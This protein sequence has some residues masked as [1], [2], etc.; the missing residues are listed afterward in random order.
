MRVAAALCLCAALGAGS[1]ATAEEAPFARLRGCEGSGP[2]DV[3]ESRGLRSCRPGRTPNILLLV[4][5][6]LGL[7][8][9]GVYG[10]RRFPTPNL[11]RLAAEGMRFTHFYSNS[12]ICSPARVAILTGQYP[13]RHGARFAYR[14]QSDHGLP[15]DVPTIPSLLAR[16]GYLT[17][18]VGKWHVGHGRDEFHPMQ[19]GFDGFFGFLEQSELPDTYRSPN[20][21]RDRGPPERRAGHLTDLLTAEAIEFLRETSG[22][23]FFLQVWFFAP[24]APTQPPGRWANRKFLRPDPPCVGSTH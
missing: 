20:L 24:H 8:E 21:R 6:D 7:G 3:G 16:A 22:R 14:R 1:A 2:S 10:N 12:S 23:P 17:H 19:R 13:Q 15:G 11:D 9:L 5:D 4:A 18:H